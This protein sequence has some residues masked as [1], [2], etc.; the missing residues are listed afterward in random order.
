MARMWVRK[1][2]LRGEPGAQRADAIEAF[3]EIITGSDD[4]RSLTF[5]FG[6]GGR[7]PGSSSSFRWLKIKA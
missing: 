5:A 4:A 7:V 1:P 6:K 3:R 2:K